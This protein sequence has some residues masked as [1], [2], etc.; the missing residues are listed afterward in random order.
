[1]VVSWK[2][3]SQSEIYAQAHVDKVCI[4]IYCEIQQILQF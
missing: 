1:V 2:L 3:V 4:K